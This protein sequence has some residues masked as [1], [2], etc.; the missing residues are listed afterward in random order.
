MIKNVIQKEITGLF[1][2][3]FLMFF[4]FSSVTCGAID[5]VEPVKDI[6]LSNNG[7]DVVFVV[8]NSSSIWPRQNIRN[9]AMSAAVRLAVGSDIN[10]G[11]VYFADGLYKYYS[12]TELSDEE[13]YNK[14][15]GKYLN[16]T[17]KDTKNRFTNIGVGLK[18]G[19]ELFE[20]QDSKRRKIIILLSDGINED[21]ND[22][23]DVYEN[24]ANL[25]T[26]QQVKEIKDKGIELYCVSIQGRKNEAYL[27]SMVNYFED[28]NN[29]D[30]TRFF[31]AEENN[32]DELYDRFIEI[33]YSLIGNVKYTSIDMDS[34]GTYPFT[35][36]DISVN[37]L[38]VYVSDP[39]LKIS[40]IGPDK[41]AKLVKWGD[42][43]CQF[44]SNHTPKPGKWKLK[45]A[46]ENKTVSKNIKVTFAYY[47][48]MMASAS[49]KPS[50]GDKLIRNKDVYI[51]A[52]FFDGNKNKIVPDETLKLEGDLSL[53]SSG[54]EVLSQK[55]QFK[56][57]GDSF[58][59]DGFPLSSYG[60][61]DLKLRVSYNS[62]INL[63]YDIKF[64][65]EIKPI[66]PKVIK[67]FEGENIGSEKITKENGTVYQFSL[68]LKDYISDE[69]SSLESMKI[70]QVKQNS[71]HNPISAYISEGMIVIE[72]V[73]CDSFS[74]FLEIE[75]EG[76]LKTDLSIKGSL[77]DMDIG[78]TFIKIFI[79]VLIVVLCIGL[80]VL[81]C[82]IKK[83]NLIAAILEG[84][85][86]INKDNDYLNSKYDVPSVSDLSDGEYAEIISKV[87]SFIG[88]EGMFV[89]VIDKMRFDIVMGNNQD[90]KQQTLSKD[91]TQN[92]KFQDVNKK[93]DS[94]NE[95]I[96]DT[97]KKITEHFQYCD[98]SKKKLAYSKEE[99]NQFRLGKV[100]SIKAKQDK[101]LEKTSNLV[102][103]VNDFSK[104]CDRI[105]KDI[106]IARQ[107]LN[108]DVGA[109]TKRLEEYKERF[110]DFSLNIQINDCTYWRRKN[111][112]FIIKLS[113]IKESNGKKLQSVESSKVVFIAYKRT[114]QVKT[115]D[116]KTKEK[117]ITGTEVFDINDSGELFKI[118][119]CQSGE[120]CTVAGFTIQEFKLSL[121]K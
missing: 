115:S 42:S 48:D 93:I 70:T 38:Q 15:S 77:K 18:K 90:E 14:V 22:A 112:N 110:F 58:V 7:T 72:A 88:I 41:E 55:L 89:P 118:A 81:I 73:R 95:M 107:A 68:P 69:D 104:D 45:L 28:T 78:N 100:K 85:D 21:D 86:K 97:K 6:A 2:I 36:P 35:L 59:S 121:V 113:D 92:S 50:D 56:K 19:K 13:S 102:K 12:L 117:I 49:L 32:T 108:D 54:K 27:K 3:V 5:S 10:I 24:K 26:E 105:L 80:G 96:S 82:I 103:E 37:K 20:N 91:Q 119:E 63:E 46:S 53:I 101:I 75:D 116:G 106:E 1:C 52:N 87:E 74:A 120:S 66:S 31:T 83:K 57:K 17:D 40:L 62:A 79:I 34:Q 114:E 8:D 23:D 84:N 111:K 109:I 67:N 76:G 33:F 44:V 47:I 29:F 43:E 9:S 98:K 16:M 51:Q 61:P 99:L 64:N 71:G 4:M 30:Q 11:C 39:S 25:L 94:L 60:T 65:E